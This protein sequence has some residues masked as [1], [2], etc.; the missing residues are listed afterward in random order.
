MQGGVLYKNLML[1]GHEPNAVV[2]AALR[3]K[4]VDIDRIGSSDNN[5]S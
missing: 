2:I 1:T 5:Q 3:E 4:I